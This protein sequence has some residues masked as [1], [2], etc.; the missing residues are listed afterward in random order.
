MEDFD[1]RILVDAKEEYSKE[2]VRVLKRYILEGINSLYNQACD[3]CKKNRSKTIITFQDLLEQ[4]PKWNQ[5]LI[6]KETN[7]IIENSKCEFF[8]DLITAVFVSHT[9]ILAAIRT[10]RKNKRINLTIPKAET[11]IHKCYIE[12][13][14]EFWKS[15]CMFDKKVSNFEQQRNNKYCEEI[16]SHCIQETIRKLLPL[17]YILRESLGDSYE[18]EQSSDG[19]DITK[20]ISK[21]DESN[22][23]RLVQNEIKNHYSIKDN[24]SDEDH[25]NSLLDNDVKNDFESENEN[26]SGQIEK[27]DNENDKDNE[28]NKD[29]EKDEIIAKKDIMKS[30]V[31][32]QEEFKSKNEVKDIKIQSGGN[33]LFPSNNLG[34]NTLESNENDSKSISIST[35]TNSSLENKE[36][37]SSIDNISSSLKLDEKEQNGNQLNNTTLIDIPNENNSNAILNSNKVIS[38]SDTSD[39]INSESTLDTS[40]AISNSETPSE[41]NLESIQVTDIGNDLGNS[42]LSQQGGDLNELDLGSLVSNNSV[43]KLDGN[44]NMVDSADLYNNLNKDSTIKQDVINDLSLNDNVKPNLFD[45]A[46]ISD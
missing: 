20:S 44:Y 19:E 30:E 14:R 26:N 13:A 39:K 28:K 10:T 5:E 41:I 46:P 24:I 8:E 27:K 34:T 33:N 11:F 2:L 22:L 16:I 17:K 35:E 31:D 7:R 32:D 3:L 43:V 12:S 9:K 6:E 23:K 4:I 40:K 21:S 29:D 37:L 45:D 25:I 42:S 15:P 1:T 36:T 38:I 18:D